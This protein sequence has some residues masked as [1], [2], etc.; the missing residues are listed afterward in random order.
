MHPQPREDILSCV[1]LPDDARETLRRRLG[2]PEDRPLRLAYLPGP[3][4]VIGTYFHWAE[5]RHDPRIPVITYSAMFYSLAALLGAVA[6]V[7]SET[8]VPPEVPPGPVTFRM[9]PRDRGASGLR[10]HLSEAAYAR[11]AARLVTAWRPDV[12]ILHSDMPASLF[13][14]LSGLLILSMH[15]TLWPMGQEP[16]RTLRRRLS[17]ARRIKGLRAAQAALCT[18]PECARQLKLHLPHLPMQIEAPQSP[19]TASPTIH[20]DPHRPLRTL[21]YVGRVETSKGVLDLVRAFGSVAPRDP[22]LQLHILGSGTA[23]PALESAI[24]SAGLE[25]RC[26]LHGHVD[27]ARVNALL[28]QTDLLICPTRTDFPE[29]L[30]LVVLEAARHGVPSL[31]SS[32]VPAA[33]VLPDSTLVFPADDPDALAAALIRLVED[34][35]LRARLCTGTRASLALMQD[36]SASWGSRVAGLMLRRPDQA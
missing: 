29:G 20:R 5:G 11:Q 30:A 6:L 8:P 18:S 3:G 15:N 23:L 24:R 22:D 34:A 31:A 28:A 27:A 36:R 1:V 35:P 4:D 12:V 2:I 9:L 26:T 16:P 21:T 17:L 7:I 32:V 19:D 13:T 10:W 14:R 25:S 33:E